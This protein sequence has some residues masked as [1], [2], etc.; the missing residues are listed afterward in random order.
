MLSCREVS[1]LVSE[2]LEHNLS[3]RRRLS[4]HLHL[5]MC[6][7]CSR[8]RRQIEGL[9]RLVRRRSSVSDAIEQA[10]TLSPEA[11]EQIKAAA[12]DADR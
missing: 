1:R 6:R 5:M 4:I 11:R 9:D 12:R 8:F 2:G 3:W 10:A 7:G